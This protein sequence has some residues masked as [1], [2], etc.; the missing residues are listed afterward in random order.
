AGRCGYSRTGRR[1]AANV[2]NYILRR[3]LTAVLLLVVVTM[4]TFA[5]FFLIPKA[6]GADPAQMFVGKTATPEAVE[7]TRVKLGLDKP[8]YIQYGLFIRGIVRGRDFNAGPDVD[9][10][11]PRASAT[12]SVP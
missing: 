2:I 11:P 12:R 6:A 7:A 5:I 9:H 8:I 1:Q 10:C 3:L 4:I